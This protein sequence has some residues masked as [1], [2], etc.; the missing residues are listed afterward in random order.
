MLTLLGS[1]LLSLF[2][3]QTAVLDQTRVQQL[4][5]VS[6]VIHAK[7]EV[8]TAEGPK[9]AMIGCSGTFV[10]GDTVL[11]A[12]HCFQNTPMVI[13][14]RG[15]KGGSHRAALLKCDFSHD[16]ALLSVTGPKHV[17]AKLSKVPQRG[18]AVYSMGSPIMFEFLLSEGIVSA[19]NFKTKGY[20]SAYTIH[21]GMINPGSSGGGLF[22]INGNLVGV[23][24]M[25]VGMFGWTGISMAVSAEDIKDFLR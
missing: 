21:T 1:M 24:T 22:D 13:W 23:N 19:L 8:A 15:P 18:E 20:K 17:S 25:S 4:M 7:E 14:V 10:T 9:L 12:A 16:L 11:T 6:V 3:P 5:D 2:T